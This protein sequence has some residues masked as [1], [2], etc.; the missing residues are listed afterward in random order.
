[1]KKLK[2]YT[3]GGARGNPGPAAFGVAIIDEQGKTI[4][5]KGQAIGIKTNNQAE[6]EGLIHAL[7][8][9]VKNGKGIKT[10]EFFLDSN[11]IVNQM[12][13]MFK[14]KAPKMRPLW[15]K[16]K[17]LE[18]SLNMD[19]SYFHIPRELNQQADGLLNQALDLLKSS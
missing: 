7:Q 4:Y 19:I 9:L 13:G 11:L 16:A 17:Q 1:M 10:V 12:N 18:Q 8:W 14:V 6:Y 15:L 2:I 3:D 5:K